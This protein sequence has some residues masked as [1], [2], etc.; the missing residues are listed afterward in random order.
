MATVINT[1]VLKGSHI[2]LFPTIRSDTLPT[3][4]R[5]SMQAWKDHCVKL[6]QESID[7]SLNQRDLWLTDGSGLGLPGS[8]AAEM[9]HHVSWAAKRL[10]DFVGREEL[11][12]ESLQTIA[13]ESRP[14]GSRFAGIS[15]LLVGASGAGKTALMAKLAQLVYDKE[16]ASRTTAF[17]RPVISRFCGTSL[18]S[19]MG[20]SLVRSICAQIHFALGLSKDSKARTASL[21]SSDTS[22]AVASVQRMDYDDAVA[23]LHKLLHDN[24]VILFIDGVDQLSDENQARS[25]ISFF[26]GIKPHRNTRIILSTVTD[27]HEKYYGKP[28]SLLPNS[29]I[30]TFKLLTPWVLFSPFILLCYLVCRVQYSASPGWSSASGGPVSVPG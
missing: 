6:F 12:H 2:L 16:Q 14:P 22:A 20:L 23:H 28:L 30:S 10:S 17:K 3:Q 1:P 18:A 26:K 24:P 4:A 19:T 25:G 8:I 27:S 29:I 15:L 13:F 7:S 9:L 21:A 11:V 5:A